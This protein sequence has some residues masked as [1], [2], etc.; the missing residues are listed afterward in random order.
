MNGLQCYAQALLKLDCGYVWGSQ[1]EI[2]TEELLNELD[3]K[4]VY[5][6]Q[7]DYYTS[8]RVLKWIGYRVFDCSGLICWILNQ[9]NILNYDMSA[10]GLKNQTNA[11]RKEQLIGGDL[12][13]YIKNGS[14]VHIGIYDKNG[15]VIH[16]QGTNYGLVRTDGN[17]Y[18]NWNYYGRIN[19]IPDVHW[20]EAMYRLI[21]IN[22]CDFSHTNFDKTV[23]RGEMFAALFKL[24]S[25]FK[26]MK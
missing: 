1:G 15:Y 8:N 5:P 4:Y 26:L 2:C 7:S 13:F 14:A 20:A 25:A 6:Y 3:K 23:T 19:N 24:G 10:E 12:C 11:I 16:C 21:E 22:G 9:L 18:I 17:E